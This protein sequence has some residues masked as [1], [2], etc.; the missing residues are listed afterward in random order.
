MNQPSYR[1]ARW[2]RVDLHLHSPG[3][4][5][6]KMPTG[7]STDD[8]QELIRRYI[9]QLQNQGIEVAAITDY[10]Q[11][12]EEWFI[13]IRAAA[14]E[15]GIYIYPGVELSFGGGIAGKQ[16]LHILAIFPYDA[17]PE[18]INRAI[19]KLL[20]YD[21]TL[22]LLTNGK[23]RDLKPKTALAECLNRLR[24]EQGCLFI[25]AHP[26]DSNGLFKTYTTGEAAELI[27]AVSPE[28][29][30]SFTEND[31][32]RLQSTAKISKEILDRIATVEN[33]D[34][35]SVEEIGTKACNGQVRCMYLKLSALD[36]LR[37]IR[38]ALRDNALLVRVGEPPRAAYTHI[39][40][41]IIEG[42]G[43]LVG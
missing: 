41:F 40:Q 32:Q 1:G 3:V 24:Q 15:E 29:I 39:E 11:I 36:D 28:A 42:N 16:G 7:L 22:P 17:D 38:L 31:R 35:H 14:R 9:A 43:F 21:T 5:S 27:A 6:F 19:D 4:H 34:N 20:D 18:A 30:E 33:S 12:R 10:Q 25:F 23:H 8:Q 2:V 26:N 13:P 37:A